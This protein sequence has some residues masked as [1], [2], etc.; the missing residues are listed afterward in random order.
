MLFQLI[1]WSFSC[2]EAQEKGSGGVETTGMTL[3]VVE[4]G[5]QL[6]GGWSGLTTFHP[7]DDGECKVNIPKW[8]NYSG[9]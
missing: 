8:P 6:R 1:V 5:R 4:T 3:D 9:E 7:T 2:Q